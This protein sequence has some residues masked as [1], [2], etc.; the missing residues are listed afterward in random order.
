M[1]SG[2]FEL[3]K[4]TYTRLDDNLTR[5]RGDR[6]YSDLITSEWVYSLKVGRR[7]FLELQ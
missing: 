2:G 1:H 6:L 3:A 7:Q 5:R 4:L